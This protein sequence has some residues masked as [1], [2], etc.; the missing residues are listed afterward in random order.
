MPTWLGLTGSNMLSDFLPCYR[1]IVGGAGQL[2]VVHVNNEKDF[3][4]WMPDTTFQ[5]PK[6]IHPS[7]IKSSAAVCSQISSCVRVAIERKFHGHT[8]VDVSVVNPRLGPCVFGQP[9]ECR[10]AEGHGMSA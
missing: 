7:D 2:K 10:P 4:L 9:Q 8:W 5:F 3:E 1:G 6:S